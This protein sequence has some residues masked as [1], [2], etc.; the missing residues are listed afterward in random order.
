MIGADLICKPAAMNDGENNRKLV[1]RTVDSPSAAA[2]AA[3]AGRGIFR[4]IDHSEM[5]VAHCFAVT[6]G[7]NVQ[8]AGMSGHGE[9]DISFVF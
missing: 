2:V 4:R 6:A 1:I 8:P 3:T 7:M 5:Q 9:K